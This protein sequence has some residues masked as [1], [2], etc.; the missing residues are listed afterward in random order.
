MDMNWSL[1]TVGSEPWLFSQKTRLITR[2]IQA[3]LW[4]GSKICVTAEASP[5][6]NDSRWPSG[7]TNT[8]EEGCSATCWPKLSVLL[9]GKCSHPQIHQRDTMTALHVSLP[10]AHGHTHP[11]VDVLACGHVGLSATLPGR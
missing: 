3:A 5:S 9:M 10:A 11:H 8:A 6:S 1:G 2:E 7:W 4:E